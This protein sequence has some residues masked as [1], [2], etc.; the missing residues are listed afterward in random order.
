MSG[1]P[2]VRQDV[3]V[4]LF[5]PLHLHLERAAPRAT[6]E[7]VRAVEVRHALADRPAK[8]F[9]HVLEWL[10]SPGEKGEA[11][12][13]IIIIIRRSLKGE[14]GLI[15]RQEVKQGRLSRLDRSEENETEILLL[16]VGS[17]RLYPHYF[18]TD[19]VLVVN[20]YRFESTPK[21]Y[22]AV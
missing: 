21:R 3:G 12:I 5:P 16:L 18:T 9:S 11:I 17:F 19:R 2:W 4:A 20:A 13:I 7:M 15:P 1:V 22:I 6:L 10:R 8:L 14:D